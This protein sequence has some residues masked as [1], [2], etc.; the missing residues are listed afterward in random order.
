VGIDVIGDYL[1]EVNV[2][3]PTC[4]QEMNKLY[5][6]NLEDTVIKFIEGLIKK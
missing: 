5:N 4:L 2:T 6:K 3:S 1:I